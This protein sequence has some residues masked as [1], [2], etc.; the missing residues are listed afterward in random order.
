MDDG[1]ALSAVISFEQGTASGKSVG[2]A[3]PVADFR[4]PKLPTKEDDFVSQETWEIDESH[5]RTV[6]YT[7]VR[8][9]GLDGSIDL[10][11]ETRGHA[12]GLEVLGYLRVTRLE[13]LLMCG[14]L[15]L[16]TDLGEGT[17]HSIHH[18]ADLLHNFLG[19][20]DREEL[21]LSGFRIHNSLLAGK[22]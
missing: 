5:L 9:D 16:F 15:N 11:E 1:D 3:M 12:A 8:L 18:R 6:D 17:Q 7:A 19:F 22:V 21:R 14:A 20:L 13:A 4:L 2:N 10:F